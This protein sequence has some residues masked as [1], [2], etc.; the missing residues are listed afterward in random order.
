MYFCGPTVYQRIHV[1]NARPFV[2]SMWLRRW[3]ERTGYDVT[4]VENIT[5]VND[6][7]YDAA[8][9]KSAELARRR[10]RVVRRGH[11]RSRPRP[12]RSR[13]RATETIPEQIALIEEL[14][15]RGSRTRSTGTCTSA[16]RAIPSYGALSNQRPDELEEQEPNP[17]KEDP[18][19]FALWKAHEA[20][21]GHVVGV[22]VGPRAARLAHRVLGDG[23]EA[24][25]PR[26]R[27]PRRRAR[28]RLPPPR[29]RA[30]PVAR[31]RTRVRA[32]LDAQRHAPVRRR[33][34]VEVA[35][36]RRH[37]ARGAR[38]VGARDAARLLPDRALAE[39]DRLLRRD[40]LGRRR[41]RQRR[42][43]N[44]F[45][46]RAEPAPDGAWERFAAAS[47]TTSTRRTRWPSSTAGA[48]TTCS[49]RALDV[50]GLASLADE[51]RGARGGRR[52]WR[53][54]ASEARDTRDF[55][56]SDRLRDEIAAL[57]WEVRDGADGF[58]LV[59]R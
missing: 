4:L 57:G 40:V 43:R 54:G 55:A 28:S 8:P 29:E 47:T 23:R 37:A 25:R 53:S 5:D 33:E 30:R 13:A 58:R 38:R 51:R 36:Q 45:R 16:S 49:I 41:P 15:E 27:D 32:D 59:P 52:R 24:P 9:G 56:E 48:T 17:R 7:I 31:R 39:A 6:K 18:R 14:V 1:G 44:A 50:F 42:F 2:I 10:D 35:R 20:G 12:A 21:R 3:L 34:D 11:G 22:A 46:G 26:V 19:D